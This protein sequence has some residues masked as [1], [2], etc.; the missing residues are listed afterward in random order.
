MVDMR[1]TVNS[2]LCINVCTLHHF[3]MGMWWLKINL[4]KISGHH[5]KVLDRDRRI[6]LVMFVYPIYIILSQAL[7]LTNGDAT[8][9]QANK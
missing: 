7:T 6:N 1:F 4:K 5:P 2:T 3:K 9:S 8:I